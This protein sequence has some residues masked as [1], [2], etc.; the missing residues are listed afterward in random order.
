[1]SELIDGIFDLS[2][3]DSPDVPFPVEF[4]DITEFTREIAAEYY[5]VFEEN[6]LF[7]VTIFPIGK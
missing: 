3:L 2:K 6:S 7:S 4:S 1:M 5:E